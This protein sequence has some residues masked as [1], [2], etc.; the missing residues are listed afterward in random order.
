MF[1]T[2]QQNRTPSEH[3]AIRDGLTTATEQLIALLS[4]FEPFQK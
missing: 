1:V 3:E 2:G 4:D